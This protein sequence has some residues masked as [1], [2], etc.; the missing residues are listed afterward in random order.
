MNAMTQIVA[1]PPRAKKARPTIAQRVAERICPNC[2]APSAPRISARGPAPLY[3]S[4]ACKVAMNNRNL[5]EGAS[6]VSYLKAWRADR[7]SGE[8]AVESFRR[9][10]KIVDDLN[11]RDRQASRPRADYHAACLIASN[12]ATV[13]ERRYG[14]DK[15]NETRAREAAVGE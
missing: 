13:D 1:A 7:G 14:I 5:A 12:A 9:I 15:I 2:G 3:C 11:D 10:C 8:I 6:L 4:K